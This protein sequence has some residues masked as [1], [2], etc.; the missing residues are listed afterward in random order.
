MTSAAPYQ[1]LEPPYNVI[2]LA[3]VNGEGYSILHF[4]ILVQHLLCLIDLLID[5]AR[6]RLER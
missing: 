1:T 4:H 2:E 5:T 6:G 3:G